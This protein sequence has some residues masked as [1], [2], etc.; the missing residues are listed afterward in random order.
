MKT[1]LLIICT[2]VVLG[3]SCKKDS[4]GDVNNKMSATIDNKAW[5]SAIRTTVLQSNSNSF[6]ITATSLT[7]E[8][9]EITINGTAVGTYELSVLPV[10][11]QCLGTY[12]ASIS[13]GTN[14]IYAST[15][16]TVVL[17]KVDKVAKVISG[18]FTF[19]LYCISST[20]P[21][22]VSSGVFNDLSYIEQ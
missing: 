11:T 7:G 17:T 15:T 13:T 18:T 19:K 9:L 14:D 12:K 3:V 16:G 8:I 22:T 4:S 6:F 2:I 1:G 5:N 21:K 20:V 10:R